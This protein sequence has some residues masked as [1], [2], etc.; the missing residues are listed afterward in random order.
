VQY[1]PDELVLTKIKR[2]QITLAKLLGSAREKVIIS[3]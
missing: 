3:N 1:N 2:E